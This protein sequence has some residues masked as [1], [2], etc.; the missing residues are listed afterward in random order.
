MFIKNQ[1]VTVGACLCVSV[2][3]F[4]AR[5]GGE[6]SNITVDAEK[7]LI[8]FPGKVAKQGAHEEHLK[9]AIEYI[10][11]GSGGKE[12]EALFVC[13]VDPQAIY[14][15]LVKTG[16]KPG[17]PAE[18]DGETYK[19]PE[20]SKVRIWVEWT[21]GEKK[22][23]ETVESFVLDTKTQKPME[24]VEW[25]F[26]GS[27]KANDPDSGKEVL[28]ATIV[29]NLI[30]LHHL[31]PSVLLQNPL[32]DAKEAGRYKSNLE[33]LPA[34]GT[35][36]TLVIDA[37]GAK[38]KA[39]PAG[40]AKYSGKYP[41]IHWVISGKIRGFGFRQFVERQALRNRIRGWVRNLPDGTVELVAEGTKSSLKKFAGSVSKGPRGARVKRIKKLDLPVESLGKFEIR[42]TPE[43]AP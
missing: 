24:P 20:G 3:V 7:G 21:D 14:D 5:S 37:S 32:E 30:S 31:D 2:L 28:Q 9:G 36:V 29:Q 13:P 8:S 23:R 19:L 38:E 15:A 35:D 12:Y 10:A 27:K 17:K 4:A 11:C 39:E 1:L 18:D 34:E 26:T 33:A 43:A 40:P 22:R 25:V 6:E 16:H 42:E 41:R